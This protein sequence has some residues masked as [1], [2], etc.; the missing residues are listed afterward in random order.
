M[1]ASEGCS[2]TVGGEE[3]TEGVLV[4]VSEGS[5]DG[6]AVGSPVGNPEGSEVGLS[7]GIIDNDGVVVGFNVGIVL[8][9]PGITRAVTIV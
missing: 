8:G 6:L 7:D 1:G 2:E 4:G 3:V 9:N 5:L